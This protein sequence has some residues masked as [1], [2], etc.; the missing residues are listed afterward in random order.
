MARVL[1][2]AGR[3]ARRTLAVSGVI[4]AVAGAGLLGS[5]AIAQA[6]AAFM[7]IQRR[8]CKRSARKVK[9]RPGPSASSQYPVAS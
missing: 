1:R 2:R 6:A 3:V 4:V 5:L 8:C 7:A 9:F